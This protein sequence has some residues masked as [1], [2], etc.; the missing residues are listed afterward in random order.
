MKSPATRSRREAKVERLELR[1]SQKQA[2]VIRQAAAITDKTVTGFVLDAATLEAQRAFADRRLFRLDAD[3][4]Q[5]FVDALDRPTKAKP[6]LRE[7]M[8]RSSSSA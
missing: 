2:E 8:R 6:R 5:R 1:T 4:W 3:H 7:L